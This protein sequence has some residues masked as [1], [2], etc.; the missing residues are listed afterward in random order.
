MKTTQI[1]DVN[2]KELRGSVHERLT[3]RAQ[4]IA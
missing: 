1:Y 2:V 3:E 4:M